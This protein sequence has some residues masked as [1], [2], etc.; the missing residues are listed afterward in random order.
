[1]SPSEDRSS[2]I[3]GGKGSTLSYFGKKG[4]KKRGER[5]KMAIV[6]L[7]KQSRKKRTI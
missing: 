1:L 4:K 7:F 5:E 3:G 2:A 6:K